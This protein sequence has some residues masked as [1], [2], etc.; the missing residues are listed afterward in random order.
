MSTTPSPCLFKP[1]K[2]RK[3]KTGDLKNYDPNQPR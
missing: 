1:R 2:S 3:P